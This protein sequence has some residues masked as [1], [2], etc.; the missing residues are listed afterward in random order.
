MS[1]DEWLAEQF[2]RHRVNGSTATTTI[3]ASPLTFSDGNA[4][5]RRRQRAR[6][7]AVADRR[8]QHIFIW[9]EEAR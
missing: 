9:F 5:M 4:S 1:E 3:A 2:E 7:P 6:W 8:R